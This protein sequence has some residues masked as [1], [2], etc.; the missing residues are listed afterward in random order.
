[1][2]SW[3]LEW[4]FVTTTTADPVG[5][6]LVTPDQLP[7]ATQP[8]DTIRLAGCEGYRA[9]V[10]EVPEQEPSEWQRNATECRLRAIAAKDEEQARIWRR[11]WRGWIEAEARGRRKLVD[12]AADRELESL[13]DLNP[14]QVRQ[15]RG[16]LLGP[17]PV[18]NQW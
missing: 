5:H 2:A 14:N 6:E 10:R 4:K 3:R 12:W 17:P 15:H 7:F 8:G 16:L 1:M 9:F 13:G 18:R 11:G